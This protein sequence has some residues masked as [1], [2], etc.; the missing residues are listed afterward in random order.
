MLLG[1]GFSKGR[2]VIAVMLGTILTAS[3]FLS[4]CGT[5][6]VESTS[7]AAKPDITEIRIGAVFP[8]TGKESKVGSA[9]KKAVE[10]AIKEVNDAGGLE[11]AGKKVQIKLTILDDTTDPTKSAQLVEQIITQEKVHVVI[12]GYSTLL[13]Q[14]QTVVPERYGIPMVIAGAGSNDLFGHS[15]WIFG[16]LSP[17]EVLAKTQMEY[18]KDLIDQGK[19]PKPSTISLVWENTDHG[20]DYEKGVQ[21]FTKASPQYF[22]VAMDEGFELFASDFKPL[23]AKVQNA[24]AD[25]FMSDTHLE[26][27]IAMHRTYTQMGLSHKMVTYGARGPDKAARDGLGAATDY[28]F[29]STWFSPLLP[30][31]QVKTFVDKWKAANDNA[32][33]EWYHATA[34]ETVRITLK[35][36]QN[37][38]STNPEKIR[39]ALVSVELK[40][41]ILPGGV[42]KFS[43]TGQAI[44]PFVVTQN[45]PGG[46]VDVVWP[47]ES[48]TG[49]TVAPIPPA[50]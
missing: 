43:R 49:D 7:N 45:K 28:I 3:L 16:V 24:K 19:L 32:S 4:G 31:P 11:I 46:K 40:D 35:A 30:S 37:A 2:Q 10:F 15:K 17:V 36:I 23:L 26:D 34:Y 1:K 12:G 20:K 44:Y 9:H 25:I 42:L 48:K 27:F 41:S 39:E 22:K 14:A 13:V 47:K 18:L 29:A 21:E 5:K 38:G 8:V 50:K 33:P 6:A